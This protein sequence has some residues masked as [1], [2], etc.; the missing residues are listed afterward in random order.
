VKVK[1]SIEEINEKIKTGKA[2]VLTAEEVIGVVKDKGLE[3]AAAS[4][5][6]KK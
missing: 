6:S 2:V 1:R 5:A 3:Q 4:E